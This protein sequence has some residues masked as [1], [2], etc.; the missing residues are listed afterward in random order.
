MRVTGVSI[1]KVSPARA[2]AFAVLEQVAE[3]AYLSDALR[4][5]SYQLDARDAGLASQIAFGCLRFEKQLDYLIRVYSGRKPNDLDRAVAIALRAAIFQMRYLERIPAHA[6][7]HE[8]VEFVKQRRRAAGGFVNAVLRKVTREEVS[9]PDEE[10]A[11]SCPEW[12]LARWRKHFGEEQARGIAKAALCEPAAYIR[13]PPGAAPP[14]AITTERTQIPGCWRLLSP[15]APGMRLHDISS[16]AVLLLLD[17]QEGQSYLDLCA[18]PGNKT[19]QALETSFGLAVACDISERRIREVPPVCPRVVLD[20]AQPLPF[21]REF[22]RILV[23][24]P[25]SGTGTLARNP[26]IKWRVKPQ[27]FPRFHRKQ[28]RIA[29]QALALLAPR[30]QLLYATCS[31]EPEENEDVVREIQSMNPGLRIE[32]E[33]WRLPGRDEG[34]G[35]YAALLTRQ[36]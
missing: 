8:S 4:E 24:A 21:S 22:D 12:L 32:R 23:D 35:F 14:E 2:V 25:C 19:L 7:V 36:G 5:Q 17:A 13:I 28:L 6:A 34:D 11:L 33:M 16:Q 15:P 1:T 27:D 20:A 26:E 18:A 9:W 30:G 10:T 3:G 31:L 29:A